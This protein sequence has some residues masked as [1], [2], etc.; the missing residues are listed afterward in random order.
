[1]EDWGPV[2]NATTQQLGLQPCLNVTVYTNAT[3]V[4]HQDYLVS[5]A[6]QCT[7]GRIVQCYA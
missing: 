7:C 2:L 3:N 4:T 6:S 5:A 1:M